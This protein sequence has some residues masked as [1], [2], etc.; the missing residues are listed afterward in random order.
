MADNVDLKGVVDDGRSIEDINLQLR[1]IGRLGVSY[2]ETWA[3]SDAW[4][5]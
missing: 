2:A 1:R 3:Q 5:H 4:I